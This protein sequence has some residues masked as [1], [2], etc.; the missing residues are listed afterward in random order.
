MRRKK[1]IRPRTPLQRKKALKNTTPLRSRSTLKRSKPLKRG[2]LRA[3]RLAWTKLDEQA[4]AEWRRKVIRGRCVIC[5]LKGRRSDLHH[6]HDPHHVLPAR[7]IRR[8]V[9]SL[10]LPAA[11]ARKLLRSLLY[12]PRNGLCL[13]RRCHDR[14]E[15]A[16]EHVPYEA[17]PQKAIQFARELGLEWVLEKLYPRRSGQ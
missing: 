11:E 16:F 5:V 6:E 8:Y 7:Y 10:Q 17:I 15:M 4:H 14:H 9:R 13:D 3:L 2:N 12:D 1:P